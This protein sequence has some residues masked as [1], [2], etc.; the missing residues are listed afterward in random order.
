MPEGEYDPHGAGESVLVGGGGG[1]M[2]GEESKGG[3]RLLRDEGVLVD[4][5]KTG[6]ELELEMG[7][8]GGDPSVGELRRPFLRAGLHFLR[9]R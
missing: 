1:G 7:L 8:Y 3:G 4:L 9:G 5:E 6:E 2:G